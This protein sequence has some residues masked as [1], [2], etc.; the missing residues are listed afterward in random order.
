MMRIYPKFVYKSCTTDRTIFDPRWLIR[1]SRRQ[2]QN[3]LLSRD[4]TP[5]FTISDKY[6]TKQYRTL[7]GPYFHLPTLAMPGEGTLEYKCAVGRMIALRGDDTPNAMARSLRLAANQVT[8]HRR[9]RN[10]LNRYKE[11]F[12]SHIIRGDPEATYTEW[13]L[14]VHPKKKLRMKT[15]A[16][17][18]EFAGKPR[19]MTHVSYK[20]KNY[21]LLADSKKRAIGDL[22]A[23]NTQDSAHDMPS[24]KSAMSYPFTHNNLT[25]EFVKTASHETLSRVLDK[26]INVERGKMYFAYH[27]DDSCVSAGCRDGPVY[28]NGDV[29]ACDGSHRTA[30]FRLVEQFLTITNGLDNAHAISVRR[31]MEYLKLPLVMRNPEDYREKV[32]YVFNTMRL[33]S[34][35][36]LTTTINNFANLFISFALERRVRNPSRMSKEQFKHAY[37]MAGEDVGYILRV[38]PCDFPEDLLFLKHFP[39]IVDGVVVPVVAL[40][41]WIRGFGTFVGDLPG[42]KSDGI[43]NRAKAFLNDVVVSRENWGNH[44]IWDSFQ[45]LRC[46]HKVVMT[47]NAYREALTSRSIGRTNIR[48]PDES[49]LRRYRIS[50]SELEELCS[51]IARSNVGTVICSSTADKMYRKDYG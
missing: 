47:G 31:A 42:R 2:Q 27:S 9:F 49:L 16:K 12:E 18:L 25:T 35:S 26:L 1:S 7:F 14:A 13:L 51:L 37:K 43:I 48:V 36:S 30:F 3:G 4:L 17:F 38:D 45:H 5:N 28:F 46:H 23:E 21:E 15:D 22:G 34:G 44:A 19:T 10:I 41:T 11:H 39:S 29:K 50:S 6:Y 32:T 8:L 40:G 24:I 33:Y 20:L